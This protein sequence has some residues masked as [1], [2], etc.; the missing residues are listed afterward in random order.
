[1]NYRPSWSWAEM[2][3]PIS[4]E[5]ALNQERDRFQAV[6]NGAQWASGLSGVITCC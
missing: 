3:V 5:L 2:M 4:Y 1:M 6:E